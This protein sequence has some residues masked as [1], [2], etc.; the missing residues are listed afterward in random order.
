MKQRTDCDM[1]GML[2]PGEN[3]IN[4]I[5]VRRKGQSVKL[6]ICNSCVKDLYIIFFPG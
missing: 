3:Y 4:F 2:R 5:S 1:N 6:Y